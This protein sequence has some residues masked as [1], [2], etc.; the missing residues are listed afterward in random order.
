VRRELGVRREG[1]ELLPGLPRRL[2]RGRSVAAP[3][4][5]S[6]SGTL[7]RLWPSSR[8]PPHAVNS[9]RCLRRASA[10]SLRGNRSLVLGDP[11]S[12]AS[13]STSPRLPGGASGG[14]SSR[15][16]RLCSASVR[17]SDASRQNS[18]AA[19][20]TASPTPIEWRRVSS[21]DDVCAAS[22]GTTLPGTAVFPGHHHLAGKRQVRLV[23][24]KTLLTRSASRDLRDRLR[25]RRPRLHVVPPRL[26][27]A[28]LRRFCDWRLDGL[29]RPSAAE[30]GVLLRGVQ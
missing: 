29:S 17:L 24:R 30:P 9:R 11:A 26:I 10:P 27:L 18:L 20:L 3:P 4:V 12:T 23:L 6:G 8:L 2:S 19:A 13:R 16:L 7:R 14:K 25:Q 22:D 28:H 15:T 5:V 1:V 21:P